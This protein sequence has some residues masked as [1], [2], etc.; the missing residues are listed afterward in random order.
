MAIAKAADAESAFA[1]SVPE[2]SVSAGATTAGSVTAGSVPA[3]SVPALEQPDCPGCT[4]SVHDDAQIRRILAALSRR[5]EACVDDGMYE[6]RLAA[7][8][9]C[10]DLAYGT[11]CLHCGCFVAVRAKFR[12]RHC[13]MPGGARW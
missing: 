9:A 5:P 6:A 8:R 3:G 13:P 7:C 10:P 2:G 11:T 1:G 4:A 12:D